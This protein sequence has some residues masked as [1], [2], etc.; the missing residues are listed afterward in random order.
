L[1]K[2]PAREARQAQAAD[3]ATRF[4]DA[5]VFLRF[6]PAAILSRP[7]AWLQ[8]RPSGKRLGLTSVFAYISFASCGAARADFLIRGLGD[9][10]SA[11]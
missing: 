8:I 10:N 6:T 9:A 2:V 7:G 5:S 4:S 3:E 11:I 1:G